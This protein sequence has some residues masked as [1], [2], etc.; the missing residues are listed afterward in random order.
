MGIG[1]A[2]AAKVL[3]RFAVRPEPDRTVTIDGVTMTISVGQ[4]TEMGKGTVIRAEGVAGPR[5]S[6]LV[7]LDR[8]HLFAN[9]EPQDRVELDD[10]EFEGV[11][12]AWSNDVAVAKWWLR[13][14]VRERLIAAGDRWGFKIDAGVLEA[15]LAA[16]DSLPTEAL[17]AAAALVHRGAD[18]EHEF[19]TARRALAGTGA[20]L[21]V[22]RKESGTAITRIHTLTRL[23]TPRPASAEPFQLEAHLCGGTRRLYDEVAPANVEADDQTLKLDLDGVVFDSDTLVRAANLAV[24]LAAPTVT[25]LDDGP[26]R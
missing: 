26:Y 20:E 2:V 8:S 6:L 11:V 22:I 5:L 1:L 13:S 24:R 16:R 10:S 12:H 21:D 14:P 9:I 25:P 18:F 23:S 19:E 7:A 3:G 4:D 15:H 17:E